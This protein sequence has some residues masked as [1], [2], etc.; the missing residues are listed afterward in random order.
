MLPSIYSILIST[1]L[2]CVASSVHA[3][4]EH[5]D[6]YPFYGGFALG[7]SGSDEDC[8]YHGYD[9]DGNDTSFKFFGGK[10]F[11]ENLAVEISFQDLGKLS[12]ERAM[13]TTTAETTGINLSLHGIIPVSSI[14]YV[15]G[16]VGMMANRL[17]AHRYRHHHQRRRWHGFHLWCGVRVRL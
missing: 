4:A 3:H 5:T 12:D 11:H 14:G 1:F 16:K 8:D 9:C 6:E 17:H 10:R 15:Y 2:L 13:L 7:F